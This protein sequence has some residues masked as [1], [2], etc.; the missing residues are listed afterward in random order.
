MSKTWL[1]TGTSS[2]LGRLLAERA[3]A[4][5]DQVIA[6]LRNLSALADLQARHPQHLHTL[7]M[8][9]TDNVSI[10]RG[11]NA[12]VAHA[13]RIDIVV[14]NAGYGLVGAAEELSDAQIERQL[15]TNL[16]GSIQL[17]RAV[18]PHL[19][20]QGG[21]RIVQVSSEGGQV[22][23]PGFSL[24]H[25]SKWGIEGFVEAVAQ[26]VAGFGIDFILAEPGPTQ[27]R[28]DTGIDYAEAMPDYAG[29]PADQVRSAV[30]AST[31]PVL[32]DAQ[33]TVDALLRIIDQP[34][35]PFRL[36]LGSTAY[37]N[38]HAA[39]NKRLQVLDAHKSEALYADKVSA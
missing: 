21:G 38:I 19:R 4:R 28:F 22:A 35:P 3:L 37:N 1:I 33:R 5:G 13:G 12:A 25:A 6:T 24:Y 29:T 34:Q 26:E 36:A 7:E 15:A 2:G 17:I 23:Y 39:L 32:G 9:L 10:R 16:T 11:V 27:T 30:R 20:R 31:F 18:L 14:S 8:E